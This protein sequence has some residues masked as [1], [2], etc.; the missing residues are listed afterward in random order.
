MK[1]LFKVILI[2]INLILTLV[3]ATSLYELLEWT[4]ENKTELPNSSISGSNNPEAGTEVELNHSGSLND[5]EFESNKYPLNLTSGKNS[6]PGFV[7]VDDTGTVYTKLDDIV[8]ALGWT[9]L[10]DGS[11]FSDKQLH[12]KIM[13]LE[14]NTLPSST[15]VFN[16]RSVRLDHPVVDADGS[17]VVPLSD[18]RDLWILDFS[19]D[20]VS[21][22]LNLSYSP[23]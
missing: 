5:S 19:I 1:K 14:L 10:N 9:L 2:S 3:C 13:K 7:I 11:V 15:I 17:V 6:V 21:Q 22:S 12:K 4:T 16:G 8:S 18:L 23:Q 20:P